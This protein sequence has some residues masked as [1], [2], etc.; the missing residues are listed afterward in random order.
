MTL[1]ATSVLGLAGILLRFGIDSWAS[2]GAQA[3]PFHTLGINIAGCFLA[4][5]LYVA[6]SE[7]QLLSPELLTGAL[8]GFAGGF[9]TFSAYSLQ[10]LVLIERG[11]LAPALLYLLG[12][13]ALGLCACALGTFAARRLF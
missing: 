12:S 10:T 9:T 6:G 5:C 8:V 13:P 7:R 11:Q 2:R 3:L 4:G 1:L